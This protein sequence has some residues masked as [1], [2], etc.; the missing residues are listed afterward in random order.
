MSIAPHRI[1]C[2]LCEEW[3]IKFDDEKDYRE[4]LRTLDISDMFCAE[5]YLVLEKNEPLEEF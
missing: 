3:L 1:S 2:L 5:C 4:Y